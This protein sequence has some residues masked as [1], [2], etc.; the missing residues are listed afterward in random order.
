MFRLHGLP[1]KMA[2]ADADAGANAAVTI[3][4]LVDEDLRTRSKLVQVGQEDGSDRETCDTFEVRAQELSPGSYV[5]LISLKRP[6]DYE[7]RSSYNL[8]VRA[9]DGGPEG[10]RAS[11]TN[12]LIEV[13]DV[14]DQKPFFVNAPYSATVPENTPPGSS[15]FKVLVRDGDTG[16]PRKVLKQ[17]AHM[18]IVSP[19]LTS[20]F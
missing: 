2:V 8:V 18:S 17:A 13:E 15:I 1:H 20:D 11:I 12:V 9:L 19:I 7:A 14:Q 5:G 4:C 3:E 16:L 10:A 6:L